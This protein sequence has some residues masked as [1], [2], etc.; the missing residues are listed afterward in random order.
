MDSF[1]KYF[2]MLGKKY[3]HTYFSK[4][5]SLTIFIRIFSR[6]FEKKKL[7]EETFQST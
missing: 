5:I 7:I 2:K 4:E 3:M 1:R 6:S